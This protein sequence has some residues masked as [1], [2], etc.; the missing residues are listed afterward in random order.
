[1]N[2]CMTFLRIRQMILST[3]DSEVLVCSADGLTHAT[4]GSTSGLIGIARNA[5]HGEPTP[6]LAFVLFAAS[7]QPRTDHCGWIDR[8]GTE[9]RQRGRSTRWP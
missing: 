3:G 5:K 8:T 9:A 1:M 6:S 2:F 4:L 7:S